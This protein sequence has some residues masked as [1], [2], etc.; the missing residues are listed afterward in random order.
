MR[1]LANRYLRLTGWSFIGEIPPLPKLV[2]VG[3]PHT[4]N[5]DFVVF[6]GA[7]WHFG[8]QARFLANR[9]L[10]RWP[11]GYLFSALGGIPAGGRQDGGV[12]GAAVS[13]FGRNAEMILVITPEG[14]RRRVSHWK[15]GFVAIAE[16]AQ[17]PILFAGI[18][19]PT[20][21]LTIG[22]TIH[23]D[24]DLEGLMDTA[25]RFYADKRGRHPELEGEVALPPNS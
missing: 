9:G 8:L 23:Y 20:K 1:W 22:P 25:R 21:T 16:Q 6:M 19:F 11:L 5:W 18:D 12:V 17:V 24:G 10:F 13:E 4:S 7:L 2:A 15:M 14:T 3:A